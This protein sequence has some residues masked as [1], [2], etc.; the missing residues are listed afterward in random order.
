MGVSIARE[1]VLFL[2]LVSF[3]SA[4]RAGVV[5]V[6]SQSRIVER[7]R[8]RTLGVNLVTRQWVD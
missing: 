4:I 8:E 2:Q 6:H 3:A 7:A 5:A 1:P